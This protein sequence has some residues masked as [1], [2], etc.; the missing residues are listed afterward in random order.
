V[1]D[2]EGFGDACRNATTEQGLDPVVE[3]LTAAG[4]G[5]DVEQTGGLTMVVT[6]KALY[7]TFG[8]TAETDGYYVLGWYPGTSWDDDRENATFTELRLADLVE[9]IRQTP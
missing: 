9:Q 8:V 7:G 1:S 4:I 5:S 6:V 3:A 2:D